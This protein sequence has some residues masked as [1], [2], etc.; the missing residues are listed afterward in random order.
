ME[1]YV[2][3][4]IGLLWIFG[5]LIGMIILYRMGVRSDVS[6]WSAFFFMGCV[7]LWLG[8]IS[9]IKRAKHK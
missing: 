1:N 2:E 3:L 9:Q 4:K 5:T 6:V 8:K 7:S